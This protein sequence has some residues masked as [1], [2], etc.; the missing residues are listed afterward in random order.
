MLHRIQIDLAFADIDPMN[1]II[2]EALHRL[3]QAVTINPGQ[4]TAERGYIV[5]QECRHDQA[6]P[7]TCTEILRY[8]TP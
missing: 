2:E 7:G 8:E 5:Y 3:P 1:D 6:P 4:P